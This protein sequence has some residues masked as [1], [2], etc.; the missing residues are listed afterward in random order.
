LDIK[1]Q[2]L[3]YK[4]IRGL[5]WSIPLFII[6]FIIFA[7]GVALLVA[8]YDLVTANLLIMVLFLCF[9]IIIVYVSVTGDN[10]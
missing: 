1:Y 10:S 6:G 9:T 3:I 7:F 5:L 2:R 8:F 4:I